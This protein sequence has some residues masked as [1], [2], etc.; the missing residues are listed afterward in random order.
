MAVADRHRARR[1]ARIAN[2]LD[3]SCRSATNKSCR[4]SNH[5]T[6]RRDFLESLALGAGAGAIASLYPTIAAAQP[7]ERDGAIR[8][9]QADLERHASFGDK[10]SGG[11]G[12]L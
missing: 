1:R 6:T 4:R 2:R 12:D 5:M 3:A 10:F 7:P 11:R 8:R 9:L